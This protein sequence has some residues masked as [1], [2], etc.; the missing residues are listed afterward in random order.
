MGG[1]PLGVLRI[2]KDLEKSLRRGQRGG[3]RV[4]V[5]RNDIGKIVIPEVLV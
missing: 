1:S 3:V 5:G 4:G 2:E